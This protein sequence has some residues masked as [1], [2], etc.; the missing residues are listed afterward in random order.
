MQR[1]KANLNDNFSILIGQSKDVLSSRKSAKPGRVD[2]TGVPEVRVVEVVV[3]STNK[4]RK[5]KVIVEL[6][7]SEV[8]APVTAVK[9]ADVEAQ[10]V[11]GHPWHAR[12]RRHD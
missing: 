5:L 10:A 3:S 9:V 2:V 4:S 7:G 11:G 8:V 6:F 12:H 1:R